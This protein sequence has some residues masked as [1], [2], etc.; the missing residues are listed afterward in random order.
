MAYRQRSFNKYH[1]VRQTYNG[2]NYDSKLEASR[3]Y[4][5][6]MLV[7][8]GQI[9]SYERQFKVDLYFYDKWG[10]TIPYKSWKIDFCIENL[11]GS[12]TLEEVKGVETADYK[13]K[14]DMLEK[15]WLPEHPEYELV[16][17]KQHQIRRHF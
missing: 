1:A 2:I 6:D 4:E 15:I 3:A 5:L 11:D 16:V 10:K 13:L 7:K 14:R 8:A 9:K 12:Y 17:L